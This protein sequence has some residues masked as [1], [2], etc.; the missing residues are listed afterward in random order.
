MLPCSLNISSRQID[1]DLFFFQHSN[2][3]SA[4][5][6][7][8]WHGRYRKSRD[9]SHQSCIRLFRRVQPQI[10]FHSSMECFS[11]SSTIALWMKV[12]VGL[13]SHHGSF[14]GHIQLDASLRIHWWTDFVYAWWLVTSFEQSRPTSQLTT[15]NW[16]TQPIHGNRSALVIV[17]HCIT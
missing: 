1:D 12:S 17:N 7:L 5:L 11:G 16:S 2:E 13:W 8:C 15:A 9:T 14:L 4:S 10:S 3:I 6:N